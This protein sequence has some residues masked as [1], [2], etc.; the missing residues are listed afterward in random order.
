MRMQKQV[1]E[2]EMYYNHF[3]LK[4]VRYLTPLFVVRKQ[5]HDE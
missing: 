3:V 4:C 1:D 5:M 2:T